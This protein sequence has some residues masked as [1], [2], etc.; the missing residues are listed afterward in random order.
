MLSS[1]MRFLGKISKMV[2]RNKL[3]ECRKERLRI[4][5]GLE[6]KDK[7]LNKRIK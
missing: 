5:L 2:Y 3:T 6:C 1:N 4:R 7:C